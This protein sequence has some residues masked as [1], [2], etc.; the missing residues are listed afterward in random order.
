MYQIERAVFTLL[1]LVS[2]IQAAVINITVAASG[3]TYTPSNVNA[4]VGDTLHFVWGSDDHTV[5]QST[6]QSPCSP[7]AGGFD[8]GH[9]DVG[10]TYDLIVNSTD[11]IW[12]HCAEKGHCP[13]GMVFAVNAPTTGDTYAA[14]LAAATGK[15]V[16]T[17]SVASGSASAAASSTTA[18]VGSSATTAVA[19]AS[20]TK[21]NSGACIVRSPLSDS[22][23]WFTSVAIM[24]VAAGAMFL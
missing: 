14:F 11:P 1:T 15:P 19:G 6:F 16:A 5:S 21:S 8:S 12:I 20:T 18:T 4:L 23:A 22:V 13:T 9:L 2:A 17:T 7:M 24:S 3:L 10:A